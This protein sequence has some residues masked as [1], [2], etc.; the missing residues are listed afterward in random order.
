MGLD[1]LPHEV[2]RRSFWPK[3]AP[4]GCRKGQDGLQDGSIKLYLKMAPK[5]VS[6][7]PPRGSKTAPNGPKTVPSALRALRRSPR[8]PNLSKTNRRHMCVAFSPFRFRWALEASSWP[9]EGPETAPR[10]LRS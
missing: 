5:I 6:D 9:Q 1:G 7:M 4:R 8:G 2:S 3:M 10:A